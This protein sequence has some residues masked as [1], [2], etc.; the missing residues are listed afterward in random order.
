MPNDVSG[1]KQPIVLV[2][3]DGFGISYEKKGNAVAMA[4]TPN[5]EFIGENYPGTTLRS[6]GIEVGLSWGEMGNSEVGHTNLGAG[7]VVYQNLPRINMAIQ[8]KSFFKMPVFMEAMEHANKNKSNLHIMGLVSNGGVHG[9]MDHLFMILK[10]LKDNKFKRKVFIHF[11]ADGRDASPQSAVTFLSILKDEIAKYKLGE[12]ATVSGRYYAM[13]RD[14]NWDR[15]KKAYDSMT[16][17]VG[18]KTTDAGKAILES[19]EKNIDDENIEPIMVTDEQGR[20]VGQVQDNDAMIFFNFRPD[21]ARQIAQAF[22]EEDFK[23]FAREKIKNL[24]FVSLTD[25]GIEDSIKVAFAPQHITRPLAK[26]VSDAGKTQ[27]HIAETEKYA[28]VTYFF[29][30]GVEKPFPGEEREIIPSKKVKS[31]DLK[32]EMSA[33]EIT[34]RAV[35][36]IKKGKYDLLVINYANGDMVGHTGNLEASIEAVEVLDK[37]IGIIKDAVL[38]ARGTMLITADHGNVEELINLAT[39]KV[40]KEHSTNPVPFWLVSADIKKTARIEGVSST[41][42]GGILADVAPTILELMGI[43]QPPEMTGTSLLN[44]ISSC[45]LPK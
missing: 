25:Y 2:I 35:A 23:G 26:A 16:K 31:F 32:P 20:P 41:E 9:H 21:R 3:M 39:G 6:S 4:K 33:A 37:N 17:G 13:D 40:D 8:D 44:V 36:E 43:P 45:P 1:K 22:V 19:Y 42:P 18:K 38:E 34:N 11:F 28:H 27:F 12:V 7:L 10:I 14:Q 15:T 30:G 24:F 29:N 5:L